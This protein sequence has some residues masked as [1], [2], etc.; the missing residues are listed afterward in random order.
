MSDFPALKLFDQVINDENNHDSSWV[1]VQHLEKLTLWLRAV[2]TLTAGTLTVTVFV[3]PVAASLLNESESGHLVMVYDKL[4]EAT[5][6][7]S[8]VN[9]WA[10]SADADEILSFSHEDAIRSVKV[11]VAA[12][13]TTDVTDFWT[14]TAWLTGQAFAIR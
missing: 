12:G 4:I 10:V 8:P 3:S 2:E 5:G 11:R 6:V 7:D 1:D 9:T 13:A 14:F